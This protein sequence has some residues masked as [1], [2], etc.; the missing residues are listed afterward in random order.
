[1]SANLD[2]AYDEFL[3]ANDK[4]VVKA[5]STFEKKLHDSE[6]KFG[7]SILLTYLKLHFLKEKQERLLKQTA[8]AMVKIMNKVVDLYVKK[9]SLRSMFEFDPEIE[10]WLFDLSEDEG[11]QKNL[12]ERNKEI[13]DELKRMLAEW[14]LGVRAQR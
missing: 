10:E 2:H 8:E 1:M 11:E 3:A 5:L 7:R 4:A 12:L 6:I 13:A 9:P 14:E